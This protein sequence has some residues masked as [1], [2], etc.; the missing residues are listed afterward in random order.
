MRGL[1][2][3]QLR[4]SLHARERLRMIPP[5]VCPWR[6]FG[7]V[8]ES[9]ASW[10]IC[11]ARSSG[12]DGKPAEPKPRHAQTR[13]GPTKRRPAPADARPSCQPARLAAD[14]WFSD[15]PSSFFSSAP[16]FRPQT[17][18]KAPSSRMPCPLPRTPGRCPSCAPT[19]PLRSSSAPPPLKSRCRPDEI[20][21]S[22]LTA[23]DSQPATIRAQTESF[24]VW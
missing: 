10:F 24:L 4:P 15:V 9:A 19:P 18:G 2:L 21:L 23:L 22:F 12:D 20:L 7:S 16:H 13:H 17:S 11:S 8:P 6:V 3:V 14:R 1:S 5:R